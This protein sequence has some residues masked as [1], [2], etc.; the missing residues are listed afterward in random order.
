[1]AVNVVIGLAYYL[2]WAAALYAPP[3]GDV[4]GPLRV[5]RTDRVAIGLALAAVVVLSVAPG[6]V[7]DALG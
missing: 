1:M 2:R 6:V 3:V 5:A 7:V 4:G